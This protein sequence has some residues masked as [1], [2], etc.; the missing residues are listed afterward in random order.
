[1]RTKQLLWLQQS[2]SGANGRRGG[3]GGVMGPMTLALKMVSSLP[4]LSVH[5]PIGGFLVGVAR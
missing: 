4:L 3:G 1:M 2:D 5:R